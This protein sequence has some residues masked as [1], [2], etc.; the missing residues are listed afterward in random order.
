MTTFTKYSS[1]E[2]HYNQS[3]LDKVPR[4]ID[5]NMKWIATEKIH[6]TNF[7]VVITKDGIEYGK[8]TSMLSW[9][10]N[11]FGYQSVVKGMEPAFQDIQQ[12]VGDTV[13]LFGE[14]AGDGIQS[15]TPY[16][17]KDFYVFDVMIGDKLLDPLDA[18][19]FCKQFS[20]K[21]APIVKVGDIND[22]LELNPEYKSI[23]P[24]LSEIYDSEDNTGEIEF[25]VAGEGTS[26]GFVIKPLVNSYLKNG[27]R[28]IIKLKSASHTEKKSVKKVKVRKE[29]D[30]KDQEIIDTLAQYITP[31]RI[32]NVLS[33]GE[34]E[35][36]DKTF[37]KVAGLTL[38]DILTEQA[39]END[40][41]NLMQETFDP[42]FVN[43]TLVGMI[44]KEVVK[45][46]QSA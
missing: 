24:K 44:I 33:H 2:N 9:E 23:T 35:L 12:S 8:R 43:K 11:F 17:D 22:L 29:I 28:V 42:P 16:G 39:R 41:K 6:G 13:R 40:G 27:S 31:A 7:Q 46:Y 20:L 32:Y 5:G 18:V 21:I 19:S 4:E 14:L 3:F 1:I 34:V 36:T 15:N 26:E 38:K 25:T 37:G 30:G 10:E 45:I